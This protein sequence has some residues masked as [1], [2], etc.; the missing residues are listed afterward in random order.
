MEKRIVKFYAKDSNKLALHAIPGHFATSNS[1]INFYIDVTGIRSRIGEAEEAAKLLA[2][3]LGHL[4]YVDTVVCMDGTEVI[5]TFL[6]KEFEKEHITSTNQHKTVYV[7]S[8]EHS[9]DNQIIFRDNT[10]KMIAGKHIVLLLATTTTGETIKKSMEGIQYYGGTIEGV[11]S[12]FSTVDYVNGTKI[13]F[14]FDNDVVTSYQAFP[15]TDCPFCKKG[16][17]IEAVVNGFGY[18]KL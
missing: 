18:S 6:A 16:M 3:G 2:R 4:A 8:P 11:A 1:H 17:K 10:K 9:R 15:K 12:L 7:I 14:L 5:G 13:H